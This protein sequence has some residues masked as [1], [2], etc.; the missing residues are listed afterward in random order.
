MP[1]SLTAPKTQGAIQQQGPDTLADL[2]TSGEITTRAC[3]PAQID[4]WNR[5]VRNCFMTSI[6]EVF[7]MVCEHPK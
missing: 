2:L 6:G 7:L 3:E 4:R 1:K 5:E